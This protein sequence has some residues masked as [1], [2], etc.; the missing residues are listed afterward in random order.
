[1]LGLSRK[2]NVRQNPRVI[3]QS[4]GHLFPDHKTPVIT[5]FL[6]LHFTYLL[7]EK[8]TSKY[9]H[10]EIKRNDTLSPGA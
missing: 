8:L 6:L 10:E 3:T 4:T 7:G 1:M 2:Y 9:R 5:Y